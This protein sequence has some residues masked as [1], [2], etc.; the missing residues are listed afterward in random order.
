MPVRKPV[1]INPHDVEPIVLHQRVNYMLVDPSTVGAKHLSFG[2][3][4]VEPFGICEPG[5]AHAKQEEIFFCLTGNGVVIVGDEQ[6]EWPISP[7]DAVFL[8][9]GIYHGLKNPYNTPLEVLWIQSPP[10][11][12][13]S[14]NPDL[15]AKA[16]RG[17]SLEGD[18]VR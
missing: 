12:I 9:T 2:M 6:E 7:K 3:V 15:K 13:F 14:K 17:E 18:Y 10:G 8:P 5:H 1:K 11:W 4:I 16:E